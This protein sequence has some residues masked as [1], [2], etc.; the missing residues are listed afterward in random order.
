MAYKSSL[1]RLG[2]YVLIRSE[3]AFFPC[4]VHLE[5]ES[6]RLDLYIDP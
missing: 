1:L 2:F 4:G 3:L 5:I 6:Y